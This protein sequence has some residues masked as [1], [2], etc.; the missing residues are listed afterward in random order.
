MLLGGLILALLTALVSWIAALC[1]GV[2]IAA[3]VIPLAVRT[4][5]GRSGFAIMAVRMGWLQRRVTGQTAR[6]TGPLSREPGG[7]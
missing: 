3:T 7:R 1:I 2:L 5:D 6:M 4:V